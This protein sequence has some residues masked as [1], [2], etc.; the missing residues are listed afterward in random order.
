MNEEIDLRMLL[1]LIMRKKTVIILGTLVVM[2]LAAL[3]AF[4]LP[5]VYQSSLIL[6]IGQIVTQ[7]PG[8]Q[9]Q[10]LEDPDATAKIMAGGGILEEVRRKLNLETRLEVIRKRLQVN[11]YMESGNYLSVLEVVFQGKSQEETVGFLNALAGIIID[12]HAPKYESYKQA[13]E[14]LIE[15]RR[16]KILALEQVVSARTLYRELGQ[17]YIDKG[18]ASTEEF[19][20]ELGE[21]DEA[22][23][24]AVDMLHLQGSLL[25]EKRHI[26]DLTRFKAEMDRQIGLGRE[27]IAEVEM[28]IVELVNRS[29]L[30]FPTRIVSPAVSLDD[31]VKPDKIKII[32]IAFIGGLALMILLV[33]TREFIKD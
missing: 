21:M 26:T 28:E 30:S 3:V 27:E 1:K 23:S 13:L 14:K 18:E 24:S 7:K 16:E 32:L 33:S 4:L 19:S 8:L 17:N 25:V 31:A 5:P 29:E 11:T 10:Y 6:E 15:F 20:D 12:R 2:V 22:N 9:E